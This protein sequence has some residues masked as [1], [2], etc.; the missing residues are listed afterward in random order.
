M[1]NIADEHNAAAA[2]EERLRHGGPSQAE[3]HANA[4]NPLHKGT[5]G[6]TQSH[7]GEGQASQ[8]APVPGIDVTK[9]PLQQ[10]ANRDDSK[11]SGE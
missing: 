7:R 11:I 5:S 6:V 10:A 3:R 4:V 1:K 8:P 2:R 9:E